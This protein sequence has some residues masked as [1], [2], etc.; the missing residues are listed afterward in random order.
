MPRVPLRVFTFAAACW[1]AA[2]PG[3]V[4]AQALLACRHHATHQSHQGHGGTPASGPCFCGE[5]TGALD[6]AVSTAAPTPATPT[7]TL[8]ARVAEPP[9]LSLFPLPTS[10]SFAPVPPPPNGVG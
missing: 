9:A 1:L 10:P 5:M 4:T 3:G 7:V 8:V 6:L 2:G